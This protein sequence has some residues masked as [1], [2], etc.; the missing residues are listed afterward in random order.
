MVA[1]ARRGNDIT[2]F[3]IES[4]VHFPYVI[5]SPFFLYMN[6]QVIDAE[7][8]S[9][10]PGVP[11]ALMNRW[12]SSLCWPISMLMQMLSGVS[13][14]I[15]K[16]PITLRANNIY[17][18]S[19]FSH[20]YQNHAT[21]ANTHIVNPNKLFLP[22]PLMC[23]APDISSNVPPL[24]PPE[25]DA[26][27]DFDADEL[28]PVGGM[29]TTSG[30][31]SVYVDIWLAVAMPL[32]MRMALGEPVVGTAVGVVTTCNEGGDGVVCAAPAAAAEAR[33]ARTCFSPSSSAGA[34]RAF[35]SF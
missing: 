29:E 35:S 27:V 14:A 26:S 2:H 1:H 15:P 31:V 19:S 9:V 24:S 33:F 23:A 22:L 6:S 21:Q 7:N 10:A 17:T 18:S 4:E 34:A 32:S 25:E 16:L 11:Y 20:S 3:K 30:G 8:E 28:V 13:N 12:C 5:L